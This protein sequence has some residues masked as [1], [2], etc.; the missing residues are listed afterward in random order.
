[1]TMRGASRFWR[2][3]PCFKGTQLTVDI[4]LRSALS[5]SGEAQPGAAEEDGAVLAQARRDKEATYPE[6]LTSRR[7]RLVVVVIETGGRWSDEAADFLWQLALAKGEVPALLTCSRQRVPL[8]PRI[9][10]W[11]P[12]NVRRG[13]RQ[14]EIA[15]LGGALVSRAAL[16]HRDDV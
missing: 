13:A 11:S 16:A 12:V 4:A 3:L 1:M 9:R 2:K 6:F 15:V 14:V 8:L 10:W 5:A 7:C